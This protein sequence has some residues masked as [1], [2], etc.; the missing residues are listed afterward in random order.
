MG[1]KFG[2]IFGLIPYSVGFKIQSTSE[3][4]ALQTDVFLMERW[5]E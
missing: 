5:F 3:D 4:A 1:K 2:L